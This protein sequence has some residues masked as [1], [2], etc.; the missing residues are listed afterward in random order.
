[1]IAF[2]RAARV[3]ALMLICMFANACTQTAT[4]TYGGDIGRAGV[5]KGEINKKKI[6][7]ARERARKKKLA[8]AE[9][10]RKRRAA[11]LGKMTTDP[12]KKTV[13]KTA[14]KAAKK[15]RRTASSTSGKST[16]VAA[17]VP[18]AGA[19][20]GRLRINAAWKCV[21]PRLK[22]VINQ[23][24]VKYGP[25]TINSTHRT[26]R[27]NRMVGGKRRSYHLR[28]QAVDFRVHANTRGLTRWLARHPLVGGYKRYRSG[29]YHIDTGPKRTW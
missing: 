14:R 17:F 22:K 23:I 6:A 20:A 4:S 7:A 26:R 21:P 11:T 2:S 13:R 18:R 28:C 16:R 19:K 1:M 27:H 10:F 25:V 8:K 12:K 24:R 29:F 15:T 9:A 3:V 5:A